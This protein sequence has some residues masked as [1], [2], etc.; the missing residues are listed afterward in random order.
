MGFS[1]PDVL[2]SIQ[3]ARDFLDLLKKDLSEI[4]FPAPKAPARRN[5]DFVSRAKAREIIS[6][7]VSY[8]SSRM[9]VRYGRIAI[10]EQKTR[11]GSCSEKGNLNFNWRLV[12]APPEI[13][14]YV[15]IHEL[16]HLAHLNHSRE[17]WN[18]V[19]EFCP[20]YKTRRRWL[21]ENGHTLIIS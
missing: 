13:R 7:S 8:W 4:F 5:G 9:G 3:E 18:K 20:E 16:S 10:R 19:A 6:S 21:K 14:D 1:I 17:F 15:V 12:L 2:P 11:W